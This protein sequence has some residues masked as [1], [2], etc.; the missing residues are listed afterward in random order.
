MK[1]ICKVIVSLL[2]IIALSSCDEDKNKVSSVSNALSNNPNLIVKT[3]GP[4]G[5]LV[6]TLFNKQK[7]GVS[8]LWFQMDGEI[9]SGTKLEL[10]FGDNKLTDKLVLNSKLVGTAYV[11]QELI[12]K[13]GDY[14][15]YLV[16]ASS[17]KRFDIGV[18]KV[19]PASSEE[20]TDVLK[21]KKSEKSKVTDVK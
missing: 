19:T 7:N 21:Q 5:T 1:N 13:A 15:L 14:P 3:W 12:E 10:W 17:K 8:A 11:S 4:K 20:A 16:E 6:G 18:F 2:L 9:K